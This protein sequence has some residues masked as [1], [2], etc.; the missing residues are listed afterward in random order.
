MSY[1]NQIVEDGVTY[2]IGAKNLVDGFTQ[3]T[4]GVNALD[5]HAGKTLYDTLTTDYATNTSVS[6]VSDRVGG[7]S[8]TTFVISGGGSTTINTAANARFLIILTGRYNT[9]QGL[10]VGGT[11]GSG[12]AAI[13][14]IEA[15]SA[16]TVDT[17][18]N[19]KLKFTNSHAT[20]T[21][22]VVVIMYGTTKTVN[23]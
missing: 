22:D 15:A 7:I 17:S 21:S 19:Y 13:K 6:N 14:T 10:I 11:N 16:I 23:T 2:D 5:A 18:T 4:A 1:I 3:S 12:T 9:H 20:N 8:T